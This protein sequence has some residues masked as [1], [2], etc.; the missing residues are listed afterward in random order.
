MKGSD[1]KIQSFTQLIAWKK[2][3]LLALYIYNIT[4]T[5]PAE[6]KFGLTDQLRRAA[7]SITS[8][9]AEGFYRRTMKDKSHF[10]SISLGSLAEIQNQLLMSR[11][12]TYLTPETFHAIALKTVEVHKLLNG[13]IKSSRSRVFGV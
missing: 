9:I 8:N 7:V 2:A 10:Y 6:E 3:H 4:K 12:L 1:Q 5:F 11:D 13:L